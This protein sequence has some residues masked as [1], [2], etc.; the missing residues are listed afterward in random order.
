MNTHAG[1]AP[2][3]VSLRQQCVL[4]GAS[5]LL[6]AR[7]GPSFWQWLESGP[8]T[9]EAA[10]ILKIK[11]ELTA[12]DPKGERYPLARWA[13]DVRADFWVP[14][15]PAAAARLPELARW[16]NAPTRPYTPQT[17]SEFMAA[18]DLYLIAQCCTDPFD[19]YRKLSMRLQRQ[20]LLSIL[21][22]DRLGDGVALGGSAAWFSSSNRSKIST[23]ASGQTVQ[24]SI[25][26]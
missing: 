7:Y 16:A 19:A 9:G 8:K 21:I 15:S 6:P 25:W 13:L 20:S 10:S 24:R 18:A 14:T 5:A 26:R 1:W 12:G 4:G 23:R 3:D 17:V 2:R 11:A 22:I